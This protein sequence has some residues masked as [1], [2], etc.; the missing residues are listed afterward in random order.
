MKNLEEIKQLLHD[1]DSDSVI[2]A[3]NHYLSQSLDSET[4]AEVWYLRGNAFRQKGDW[5]MA[6]NAYLQSV[7][8]QPDGPA[9]ASC[10]NLQE[11]LSFYHTDY[12][13]P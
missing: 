2:E 13:N 1:C 10:E 12:Y 8:I 5:K 9:A 6:M 3:T 11:I 7:E 4:M